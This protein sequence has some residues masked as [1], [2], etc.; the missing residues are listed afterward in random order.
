[1]SLCHW[2]LNYEDFKSSEKLLESSV[3]TVRIQSYLLLLLLLLQLLLLILLLII[4]I[5][6][7]IKF[8]DN[9]NNSTIRKTLQEN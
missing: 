7:C 4:T 2:P 6:G 9:N 8:I 3:C 1:M 5:M